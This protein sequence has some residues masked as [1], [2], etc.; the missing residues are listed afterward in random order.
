MTRRADG[1]ADWCARGHHCAA[2]L[3]EHRAEPIAVALPGARGVLTR[4]RDRDGREY[5]EIRIRIAL[6]PAEPTARTQLLTALTDLRALVSRAAPRPRPR[7][8]AA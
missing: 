1:H 3:G 2:A 8:H 4:V 7:R 5:A 6:D